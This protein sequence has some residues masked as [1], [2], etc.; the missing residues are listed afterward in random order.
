MSRVDIEAKDK[1]TDR[2]IETDRQTERKT[3]RQALKRRLTRYWHHFKKSFGTFVCEVECV[4]FFSVE[5]PEHIVK[6]FGG[7]PC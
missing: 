6:A 1:Q 2:L 5:M 7:E 4:T 3:N